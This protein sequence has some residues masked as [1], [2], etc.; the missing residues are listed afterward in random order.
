[1]AGAPEK[2]YLQ[3]RP[4]KTVL[5]R[6]IQQ[7]LESVLEHASESS[8]KRLPTYVENE[9]RRYLEC[10]LHAHGFARAVCEACGDELLL[11][12]SCSIDPLECS[13]CGGRMG[14][15]EVIE[16][17]GRARSELRRRNLPAEPPPLARARAPDWDD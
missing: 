11:P 5:Y 6:V 7:H 9:F 10:R 8:G 3:R 16:D 14:F 17:V 1:M 2:K 13:S 15:M 4:E 12:F